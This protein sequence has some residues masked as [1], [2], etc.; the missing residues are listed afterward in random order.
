M[1]MSDPIQMA[2]QSITKQVPFFIASVIFSLC[3][4]AALYDM[5]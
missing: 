2:A 4:A 3:H 1:S 5:T